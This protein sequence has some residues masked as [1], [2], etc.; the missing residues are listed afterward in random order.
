MCLAS[1]SGGRL[2]A[3]SEWMG[4]ESNEHTVSVGSGESSSLTLKMP[5][6]GLPPLLIGSKGALSWL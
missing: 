3:V 1:R 2:M 4:R 5:I 6:E